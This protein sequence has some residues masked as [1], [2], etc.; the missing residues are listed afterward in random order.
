ME[1]RFT[2]QDIGTVFF[3]ELSPGVAQTST[4]SNNPI[5][6]SRFRATGESGLY[7]TSNAVHPVDLVLSYYPTLRSSESF[8][9]VQEWTI[10]QEYLK[11]VL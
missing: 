10:D 5:A 7:R 8:E 6:E 2:E 4:K 9:Y 3:L 11:H 1:F